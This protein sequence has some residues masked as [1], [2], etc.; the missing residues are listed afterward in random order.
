MATVNTKSTIVTNAD[1]TPPVMTNNNI[2]GGRLRLAKGTVAVA[3]ADDDASTFRIC[4]IPAH[5]VVDSIYV[6]SDALS[7][8]ASYAFGV[9]RTAADG[10]AAVDADVW[11]DAVD[12][13]AAVAKTAITYE[14]TATDISKVEQPIWQLA[15]VS[16]S[17]TPGTMYDVVATATAAGTAAGDITVWVY[18]TDG[19]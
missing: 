12:L 10:A 16:A 8:G 13:S 1:A 18:Y 7:T 15:G 17:P 19:T 3:A 5:C 2:S 14:K 9:Y 11:A 4:R 6:A